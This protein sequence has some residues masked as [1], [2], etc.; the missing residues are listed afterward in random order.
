VLV[1]YRGDNRFSASDAT[2]LILTREEP[3][4]A[5]VDFDP[6]GLGIAAS[7]PM[8]RLE[9]LLWPSSDWLRAAA[10]SIQGRSMYAQQ[11]EQWSKV[12]DDV[13]SPLISEAWRLLKAL[14]AGVA[15]ERMRAA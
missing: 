3:L 5:M 4:W 15:Q 6:A 9:R 8:R 7:L 1:V 2:R 12:L 11:V 13:Q 14:G 10:D